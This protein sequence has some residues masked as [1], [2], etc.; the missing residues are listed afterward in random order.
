MDTNGYSARP[1][2]D[3]SVLN[4]PDRVKGSAGFKHRC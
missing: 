1:L 4:N 3:D 2:L